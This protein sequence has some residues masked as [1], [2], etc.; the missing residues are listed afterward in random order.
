MPHSLP[1]IA[2][3]AK[4]YPCD[5]WAVVQ[6][7]RLTENWDKGF[8]RGA[9]LFTKDRSAN[10]RYYVS[11]GID[12]TAEG[13]I[14]LHPEIDV[15]LSVTS[16]DATNNQMYGF[17]AES[18]NGGDFAYILH[19]R[20]AYKI[21]L[22]NSPNTL[23][24]TFTFDSG[25]VC[26]DFADFEGD[27]YVGLGS[28]VNARKLTAIA[29]AGAGADTWTDVG[30]TA[31]HFAS[32]MKDGVAQ[33]ARA[34]T[35][36]LVDLSSDGS[37]FAGDDFEVGSSSTAITGLKTWLGE[38]AVI[39]P[40][41]VFRFDSE[42]SAHPVQEFVSRSNIVTA[43]GN[44]FVYGPYFY[45]AH[46]NALW[47]IESDRALPIGPEAAQSYVDSRAD[48]TILSPSSWLSVAA[49]SRWIYATSFDMG[50]TG[51]IRADGTVL[52]HGVPI[53]PNTSDSRF[54]ITGGGTGSKP[55]LWRGANNQIIRYSLI[56]DGSLRDL[57][58]GT[59]QGHGT[60]STTYKFLLP[61]TGFGRLEKQKQ[62]RRIAFITEN[63]PASATCS[64]QAKVIRDRSSS[65]AESV[66]SASTTTGKTE[67]TFTSGT[68]D[69]CFEA[70]VELVWTTTSGYAPSTSD[71]R[72]RAIVLEAVTASVYRVTIPLIPDR[73]KGRRS[74]RRQ[75]KDLRDL[76]SGAT[77]VVRDPENPNSTFNA[78]VVSVAEEAVPLGVGKVGYMVTVEL[79]RY[80]WGTGV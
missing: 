77:I 42:G 32:L 56:Q 22:N 54:V 29:N 60:A 23:E 8:A 10:D 20:R 66:G 67:A 25:A 46:H 24:T 79:E 47:L 18:P 62:L 43:A 74:I 5:S 37:S 19:G 51:F 59:T 12:A 41:N 70:M 39:K 33:L 58:Q 31:L 35:T 65:A 38:L 71:P 21:N 6:G 14:R 3:D 52:W 55:V 2:I 75:L 45:W 34:H 4:Q 7:E 9:G 72:V 28:S 11:D 57:I 63:M 16:L 69:L 26:G 76:K 68:N 27:Y 48:S 40:D 13:Y 78:Q 49:S 64:I 73:I 61:N 50:W 44:S 15:T 36:N 80:D 1:D 53:H 17:L 30:V